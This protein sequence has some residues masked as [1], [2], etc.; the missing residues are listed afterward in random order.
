MKEK[1]EKAGFDVVGV[2]EIKGMLTKEKEAEIEMI[3]K[4]LVS[5]L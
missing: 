2:I 5:K 1:L 4:K 3:A